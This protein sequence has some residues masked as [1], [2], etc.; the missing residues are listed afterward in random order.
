MKIQLSGTNMAEAPQIPTPPERA[1]LETL[2]VI[3]ERG[4]D[5]LAR[6][7][8][9]GGHVRVWTTYA[10]AP[11]GRMFGLDSPVY[12][13]WPI[14]QT[15]VP[16]EQARQ[17]LQERMERL[18]TLIKFVT[19]SAEKAL[20]ANGKHRVFIGHGRSPL[21]RELKD[22]LQD[23]LKLQWVEFNSESTA[24]LA[25]TNRLEEMLENATFAFLIMTGEDEHA[26]EKL[27]ARENVVHEVGLF[28]GRLGMKRAIILHE[29]GCQL[30]SNIHGLTY[31]GFPKGNIE[32]AFEQIRLVLERERIIGG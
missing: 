25:T 18:K 26:D 7:D 32:A 3:I 21:W 22:F 12:K 28:Q 13:S 1:A 19:E 8:L 27:H 31:I 5:F 15:P 30:F 17:T 6:N 29:D 16:N 2:Q 11:L 23:R 9:T 4:A 14:P 20:S 24:G 10:R